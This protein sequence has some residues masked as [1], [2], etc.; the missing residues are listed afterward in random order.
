MKKYIYSTIALLFFGVALLSSCKKETELNTNIE[1]VKTLYAPD[2]GKSIKLQPATSAAVLFEW[3][4]AR[5]ED[6][7]L[8]QY[9]V[10][11]DEAEGDFST[12]VFKK[13]SDGNGVQTTLTVSHKDLNKIANLAGIEPLE[14]G[15]LKWTIFSYKGMNTK[16]AEQVRELVVERPAGFT[17]I[18]ADVYLTGSAT[19]GGASL[20]QAIKMKATANGVFEVFTKLKTGTYQFVDKI[21][22]TPVAYSLQG[23]AM[24][25][26]G[27]NTQTEEKIYRIRLDFNNAANEVTEIT[28]VGVYMPISGY[29]RGNFIIGN[30]QYQGNGTW[31]A[32]DVPVAFISDWGWPEERYKFQFDTKDASGTAGLEF[33]GSPNPDNSNRPDDPATPLSYFK[34]IPQ[35]ANA[36]YLDW[37]HTYK[38][39][40]ATDGKPCDFSVFMNADVEFYYHEVKVN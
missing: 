30:L 20:S 8:V 29:T 39:A 13:V 14:T 36:P 5:A 22:G 25:E 28:N 26:G 32:E 18:P 6:G 1:S 10:V 17:D 21:T 31:K 9:E 12:P 34:L 37:S 2:N 16:K 3:E 11:F 40:S 23:T 4:A 35:P 27:E 24:K 38:F 15:T 33:Y 19:E 7:T